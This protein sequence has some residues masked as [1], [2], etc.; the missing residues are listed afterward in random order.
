MD[1]EVLEEV[2]EVELEGD[3]EVDQE[4]DP[5]EG[6]EVDQE[7]DPEEDLEVEDENIYKYIDILFYYKHKRRHR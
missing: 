7:V 2:E 4:G 3:L 1:L 5:E 6:P